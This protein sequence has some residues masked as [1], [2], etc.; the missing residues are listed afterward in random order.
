[1]TSTP[2]ELTPETV[3]LGTNLNGHEFDSQESWGSRRFLGPAIFQTPRH[4]SRMY[5]VIPAPIVE[6]TA[7][8]VLYGL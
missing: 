6:V 5:A 1:M 8:K 4:P 7:P 2:G 3:E